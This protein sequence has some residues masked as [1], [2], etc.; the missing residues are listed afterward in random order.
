M[1]RTPVQVYDRSGNLIEET[2]ADVPDSVV[3]ADTI[4]DRLRTAL[5]ANVAYLALATPT[6]AQQRT[7]IERL[8]RQTN[9]LLRLAL[10]D[11]DSTDGT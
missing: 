4:R 7:Q 5:D 11:V 9:A 10:D 3:N 8:T 6:T 2:F 1:A